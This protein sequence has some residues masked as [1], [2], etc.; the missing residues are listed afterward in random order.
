MKIKINKLNWIKL[1]YFSAIILAFFVF[2][3]SVLAGSSLD[4]AIT[5]LGKT[6]SEGY[7]GQGQYATD[8]PRMIGQVVGALLA[9][10]GIIF[11]GLMIYG[12]FIWMTARGNDQN[13][14]KAKDLITAAVIGLII[15]LAAY[16]ITAYIGGTITAVR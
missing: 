13:V 11:L 1:L 15:V 6:A 4:G 2:A 16:A 14:A 5:N 7:G 12:G 8:L 3:G 9:F 10:L